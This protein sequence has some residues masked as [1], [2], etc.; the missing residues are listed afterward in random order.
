MSG[1]SVPGDGGTP[2]PALDSR[3]ETGSC[4][5]LRV[6]QPALPRDRLDSLA[7]TRSPP[8]LTCRRRASRYLVT[9]PDPE[10]RGVGLVDR[11]S[12]TRR[13]CGRRSVAVPPW[14]FQTR[15]IE[16]RVRNARSGSA[17]D[18]RS[19]EGSRAWRAWAFMP[20]WRPF[21]PEGRGLSTTGGGGRGWSS[22]G[23]NERIVLRVPG[24]AASIWMSGVIDEPRSCRSPGP[25]RRADGVRAS[26]VDREGWLARAAVASTCRIGDDAS[27]R[28]RHPGR[29][30]ENDW[31]PGWAGSPCRMACPGIGGRLGADASTVNVTNASL[32]EPRGPDPRITESAAEPI[33][34][35]AAV[36]RLLETPEA[37]GGDVPGNG[38]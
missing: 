7:C 38:R 23:E 14:G 3:A 10:E 21:A 19:C 33:L 6:A 11:P 29:S 20:P 27:D 36:R 25:M 4:N 2:C 15:C 1:A 34:G 13:L 28:S 18:R 16:A 32:Q 24:S 37:S 5:R 30:N 26:A 35:R 17:T 12:E 9:P 8:S 22:R 31:M